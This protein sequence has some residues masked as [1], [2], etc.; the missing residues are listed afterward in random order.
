[1]VKRESRSFAPV[2]HYIL[3]NVLTIKGV[4]VATLIVDQV[5]VSLLSDTKQ[6]ISTEI[7]HAYSILNSLFFFKERVI[8]T[9]L[10]KRNVQGIA[11]GSGSYSRGFESVRVEIPFLHAVRILIRGTNEAASKG[12]VS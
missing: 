5:I 12:D 9:Q 10:T 1:M 8:F 6:F 2:Y 3:C 7:A 4:G 11:H